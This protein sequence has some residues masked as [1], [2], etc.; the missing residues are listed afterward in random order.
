MSRIASL[1]AA[2][3]GIFGIGAGA[4]GFFG[5]PPAPQ[6]VYRHPTFQRRSREPGKPGKPGDKMRKK[7]GQHRLGLATLR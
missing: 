6:A 2:L 5:G 7:V 3:G 1:L 4:G